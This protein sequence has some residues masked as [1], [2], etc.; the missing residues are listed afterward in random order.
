MLTD[1]YKVWYGKEDEILV[2]LKDEYTTKELIEKE[3][4]DKGYY[5]TKIEPRY[6]HFKKAF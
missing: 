1:G 2:E 4:A 5:T 6:I 3:F